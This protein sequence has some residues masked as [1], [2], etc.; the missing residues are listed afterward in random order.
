MPSWG[1]KAKRMVTVRQLEWAAGFLDGEGYFKGV[2]DM[3]LTVAQTQKW[4]LEKL[5]DMFGGNLRFCKRNNQNPRWADYWEWSIFGSGAAGVMM[6]LW[7]LMSPKKQQEIEETLV[8]WKKRGLH[9]NRNSRYCSHAHDTHIYGRTR[10][11][12]CRECKRMYERDR[13]RKRQNG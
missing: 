11:G 3:R 5:Q 10:R 1:Q 2:A 4:P 7:I 12:I 13:K 8:R 6:T 9:A